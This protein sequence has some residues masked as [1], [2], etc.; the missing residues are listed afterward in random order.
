MWLEILN[1]INCDKGNLQRQPKGD[2]MNS[3]VLSDRSFHLNVQEK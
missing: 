3:Y 1:V 2:G